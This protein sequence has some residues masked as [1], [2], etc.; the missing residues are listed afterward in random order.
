VRILF[1]F[2]GGSGHF[3]PTTPF[4]RALQDRGHEVMYACQEAM[5]T[6]VV[7]AGWAAVATGGRTLLAPT[8]RRALAPLDRLAEERVMRMSFAGSVARERARR[9]H[10][11]GSK[12][13]PDMIV[14]DEVDF[15]GAVAA[16][17]LGIPHAAVVVIAAG[18]LLRPEVVGEPLAALRAEWGLD[19]DEAMSM[20]HRYLTIVPAPPTYRDPRDPLPSTAHHVRPAVL[21]SLRNEDRSVGAGDPRARPTVYFTLGTIFHQEA[22]DLFHRVIAGVSGLGVNVVVTV[23]REIDTAELGEQPPQVRVEQF[24]PAAEVLAHSDIVVSHGGSGTVIGAL[25]FGLPQVL[26]PMG[27]DQPLNAD[28]CEALGVAV[29]LDAM[30]STAEAIGGATAA[31]LA[32]PSWRAKAELIRD[33]ITTLPDARHA[34]SLL[35]Q[36]VRSQAPVPRT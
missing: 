24:L 15:A 34:G 8:E 33:E 27:A 18:G 21:E 3:F 4:A 9:L 28:R 25:A 13:Q 2:S 5:V 35:E 20:L 22:G 6:T 14:R 30:S 12:W 26:L 11:F 31:V 10:E 29:A 19:P 16:E 36:L 32:D 23:G 7:S 1:T 17:T